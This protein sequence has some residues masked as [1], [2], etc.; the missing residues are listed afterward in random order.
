MSKY[1]S[2][3]K[4]AV[5][6]KFLPPLSRSV[7]QLVIE[8]GISAQ[9]LYNWRNELSLENTMPLS[10]NK[11]EQ[12]SAEAKFAAVVETTSLSEIE[13]SQY[14]R[15]K[16]LLVEQLKEW[17]TACI[18]GNATETQRKRV[19]QKYSRTDKKR[20]KQLERELNRKE[21]ALAEAA[22]LLMLRKKLRA[23]YGEEDEES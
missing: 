3:R 1:S 17:R 22:A 11:P 5:L 12:W 14:C 7:S 18:N 21:K 23:Y 9:T 4:E 20:I 10:T 2:E 19:E 13:L 6:R 15:E 16:G 8:E